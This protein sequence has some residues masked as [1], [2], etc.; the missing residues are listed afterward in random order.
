MEYSL[1]ENKVNKTID[2]S[3]PLNSNRA[4]LFLDNSILT[5]DPKWGEKLRNYEKLKDIFHYDSKVF[6]KI[7]TTKMILSICFIAF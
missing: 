7:I 1:T 2:L 6:P 3:S 4:K 5:N